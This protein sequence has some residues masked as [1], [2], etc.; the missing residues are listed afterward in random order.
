MRPRFS[1]VEASTMPLLLPLVCPSL[2]PPFSTRFLLQVFVF[3]LLFFSTSR[4]CRFERQRLVPV[5][6]RSKLLMQRLEL[7]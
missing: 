6:V 2:A 4:T 3:P 5:E 1:S 7:R